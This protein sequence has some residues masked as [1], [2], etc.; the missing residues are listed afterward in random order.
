MTKQY[1]ECTEPKLRLKVSLTIWTVSSSLT[2]SFNVKY[3]QKVQCAM[4]SRTY[5]YESTVSSKRDYRSG[6]L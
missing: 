2:K 4:P 6:N 3:L 5:C 1:V